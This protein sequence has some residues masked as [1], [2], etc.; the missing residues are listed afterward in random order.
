MHIKK[1]LGFSGLRNILSKRFSRVS[2]HREREQVTHRMHDVFMSGLAMMCFQDRSLLEFQR[3]LQ[4]SRHGNNLA[5]M[6]DVH[7]IPK[8]TQMR[9]A[10]D[11]V[12]SRE[13]EPLF[14]D[15]F[16][17][18]QRGN[19]LEGYRVFGQYYLCVMDG[20]EYFASEKIQCPSCLTRT[21]KKKHSEVLRY[22]HQ[23]VQPAIVHPKRSQ[24]I[25]LCPEEVRNTDGREKQ[26]CEINAGKRLLS[27]IRRSHPKL[28]L[29]IVADSLFS[30]QPFMEEVLSLSM[31]YVLVAKPEDHKT[32]ME[33]VKEQRLL[34]EVMRLEFKD[35]G[36]THIYEWI[37]EVPLNDKK[38]TLMVNYF[39]YWMKEGERTAYHN[40]WVTDFSVDDENVEELVRIGRSRW[41]VENEVFNTVKN[42]GYHIDHNYGHGKKHLSMNFFMLN[43]LAFF[44]HQIF[45]MSDSLYQWLRKKLGS[46]KNLWDHLRIACHILI[47]PSWEAL[48]LYIAEDYG[49]T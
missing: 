19:H 20:G 13:L 34:K 39:A 15:F 31:R 6:F 9:D 38:K 2:D 23:I 49:F 27:K 48:L 26:D 4:S 45:E 8:D 43:L 1:H 24:V 35:K 30:K 33:W 28:P 25:P 11:E 16:R 12:N 41:M 14:D 44:M 18:V 46:K 47:F 32:L 5:T 10:M 22:A 40:S 36:L 42:H 21:I 29:I 7:S 17:V 37:N 3:R